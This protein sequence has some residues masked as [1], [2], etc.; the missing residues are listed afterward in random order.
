MAGDREWATG[1]PKIPA[2]LVPPLMLGI[3]S[4]LLTK[5]GYQKSE[6]RKKR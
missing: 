5:V 2:T 6:V 4:H 1:E 3:H